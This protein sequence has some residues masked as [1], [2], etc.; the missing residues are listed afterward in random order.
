MIGKVVRIKTKTIETDV[1]IV[2][3]IMTNM[4][5]FE[6][7]SIMNS[8]PFEVYVGELEEYLEN[9]CP[10]IEFQVKDIIKIYS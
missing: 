7:S 5:L 1:I 3:K 10:L 4:A 8:V 6:K 2:D 9:S